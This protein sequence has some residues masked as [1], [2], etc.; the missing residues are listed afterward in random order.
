[1]GSRE[2]LFSGPDE[3]QNAFFYQVTVLI[4]GSTWLAITFQL[5]TVAPELSITYRSSLATLLLFIYV[6]IRRLPLRFDL[7]AHGFI[8]LQGLFLFSLNYLLVY[9]AEELVASGIVAA[10]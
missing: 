10:N 1:M 2:S 3:A 5:G 4:W 9:L 8:A 6:L 7:R